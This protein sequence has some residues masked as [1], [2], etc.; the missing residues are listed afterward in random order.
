VILRQAG[1]EDQGSDQLVT[2]V[3]RKAQFE[4]GTM[5]RWI[6]VSCVLL[7]LL[8]T[9]L[10]AMHVHSDASLARHS[11]CAVCFSVQANA[12]ALAFH[13][14]PALHTLDIV[15]VAQQAE[16]KRAAAKLRLFIRPPPSV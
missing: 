11:A 1:P 13:F 8:M 4:T 5:M 10:E 6:A 3:V 12:P 15:A 14:L 9:G 7:A 16:G 2:D